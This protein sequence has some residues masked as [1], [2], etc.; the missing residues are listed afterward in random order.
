M[1]LNFKNGLITNAV[2][3]SLKP[4]LIRPEKELAVN[5]AVV[6][7]CPVIAF[8][9]AA[10]DLTIRDSYHCQETGFLPIQFATDLGCESVHKIVFDKRIIQCITTVCSAEVRVSIV[11][12]HVTDF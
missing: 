3:L 2:M 11:N 9:S 7:R 6:G 1:F 8:G 4:G 10:L 12:F 5:V